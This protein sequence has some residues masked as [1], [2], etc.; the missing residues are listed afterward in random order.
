M[1]SLSKSQIRDQMKAKRSALSQRDQQMAAL[2]FLQHF[3]HIG[4]GF[5]WLIYYEI[6]NELP[7]SVFFQWAVARGDRCYFPRVQG[8]SMSFHLV[9]QLSELQKTKLGF[10]PPPSCKTWSENPKTLMLVPGLA[11]SA[12]SHRLGFGKAF[13]DRFLAGHPRL[14]RLGVA[15]DFQLL[16][17]GWPHE[18]H[19]QTMD[20]ILCPGG[21]WGSTRPEA[22]LSESLFF[23]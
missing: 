3:R 22:R 12:N 17:E 11:F 16:A 8:D 15:Y 10:Q 4:R 18:S 5:E 14:F 20:R 7:L 9:E 13:Y 19:D 1:S 6:Q 23:C 21:V 2:K